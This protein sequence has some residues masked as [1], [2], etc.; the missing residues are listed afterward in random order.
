MWATFLR[1]HNPDNDKNMSQGARLRMVT[2]NDGTRLPKGC[3]SES[4]PLESFQKY[5]LMLWIVKG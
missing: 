5:E 1:H 4:K 3:G 2:G